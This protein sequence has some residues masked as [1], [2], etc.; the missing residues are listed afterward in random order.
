MPTLSVMQRIAQ[1]NAGREPER[2]ALKYE[3]MARNP[4]GFLRG[5][6][7]LFHE[8]WAATRGLPETPRGW[9][10]GDLHLENFGS[11]K[12]DNRLAYFDLNDFDEATLAPCAIDLARLLTSLLVAIHGLGLR[13]R[14]GLPLGRGFLTAYRA[15]LREGKARWIERQTAE[16]MVRTLLDEARGL[17]RARLLA[18]RTRGTGRH[19]QLKLGK[20]ALPLSEQDRQQV[21]RIL[22]RFATT[23]P[24]PAFYHL[25]DVARRV[26]GTAS[27][28]LA[29]YALLVRG[30]GGPGKQAILDLKEAI[31]PTVRV[32]TRAE[33]RSE[34]ERVVSVQ[35]WAQAVSPALL[36]AVHSGG[37]SYVLRELQPTQNR[38]S[39]RNWRG[40][41][42]QLAGVLTTMGQLVA[43]SH[44]R[45]SGRR[46]AAVVD[47]WID[48]ASEPRWPTVLLDYAV[49]ASRRTV[50]MWAEFVE[51]RPQP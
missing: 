30:R 7:H 15:G 10:T 41:V 8:D 21:R 28:G 37:R 14:D 27:L 35:R 34:A 49:Q 46:G 5:T 45:T 16:G 19:R 43:W 48:F 3:A 33:W 13:E 20:R 47:R 22:E 17:T 51:D 29:R 50:A 9:I 6:S 42:P 1:Y 38:L 31:A 12:G 23:Q 40:T 26:A 11:Y 4:L 32:A 39:I 24:D 44:L 25:L 36:H 2:L 18:L